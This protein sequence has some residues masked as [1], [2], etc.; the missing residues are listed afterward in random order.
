MPDDPRTRARYRR[1]V[2]FA[3]AQLALLW[4]CEVALPRIGLGALAARGRSARLQ[5]LARRFH[6]LA[7]DLGGLMIK[8]GQFLSSRLDV[9]PPEITEELAGLQDEVPPVPFSEVRA[10]AEAELGMP[11]ERAYAWV[12]EQPLAA[13]SLGQVHRA[14]LVELDA[15]HLGSADAVV[16]VQR[17][18]IAAIVDVDLAAL[19][20][21]GGWLSHVRLVS[22]R[23][24][25]PALVEEFART[26]LEEIDYLHEAASAER[27]AT[28][29]E[30]DDR[31]RA[32]EVIWE[33][34]TRRVLTLADVASIKITD[35][36]A[37]RA[38]GIDPSAVAHA[39]AAVMFDQ[40]FTHGFFHA[41]P[42]PGNLFV[43]PL[44]AAHGRAASDTA[45]R[46]RSAGGG[47]QLTF[48]DFGMMGQVP[49]ST[50]SGLRRLLIAGSQRDG[51]GLVDAITE[52][53]ALL[54]TADTVALER[55]MTQA[56][57]RF[58]GMGFAELKQVDP[59]EYRAFA[60][61]FGEV[62]RSLPFQL[63]ED[64]L[65]IIRAG[66]LTSGVCSALDASFNVWDAAEPYAAGLLR[67]EAGGLARSVLDEG[68]AVARIAARLPRRLDA[69]A[70][71]VEEGRLEVTT[72]RL[73]SRVDR[74]QRTIGRLSSAVVF[75][76]LLLAGALVRPDDLVLGTVLMVGS[77]VPLLHAAL[78]GLL[79]RR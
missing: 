22:R 16:K 4:W 6:V 59:R 65:L 46:D 51:A 55:A 64:L 41:D 72:P 75:A 37:L 47:W 58:G 11:L 62:M 40:L 7:A 5:R 71:R 3:A 54:P 27:F 66:S 67:D 36:E 44:G 43:T 39:F 29:F 30:G 42:H 13:A 53:G 20:R 25:A 49:A 31:V 61:E 63:P 57:A 52:L 33:R 60:R 8:V 15:E 56:F 69:L 9:L 21:V 2:R 50:R 45:V 23:V 14:R 24:D 70:T 32:P 10:L 18:G 48:I 74:L 19:R 78:G 1:I 35:V 17:P 28:A 12:E 77:A 79:D 73:S 26:S 38:A 76:G 68:V 34:T